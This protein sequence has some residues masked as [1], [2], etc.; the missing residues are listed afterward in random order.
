MES[1]GCPLFSTPGLGKVAQISKKQK[2]MVIIE[3]IKNKLVFI[4]FQIERK[5]HFVNYDEFLESDIK[6]KQDVLNE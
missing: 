1:Q 4:R 2:K 3:D 5:V 6:I